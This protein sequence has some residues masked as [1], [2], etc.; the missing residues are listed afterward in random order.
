MTTIQAPTTDSAQNFQL[1]R[2]PRRPGGG[3]SWADARI[4]AGAAPTSLTARRLP[5]QAASGCL[6]ASDLVALTNL[7]V[8]DSSAMDGWAVAGSPPWR[9]VADLPAGQV[10][11]HRL[12][13]GQCVRIATGAVVPEGT[14][15]VLPVERSLLHETG[16]R[17]TDTDTDAAPRT[18][19]RL[20]GEEARRGDVLLPAGTRVT[21]PVLGLAAAAGHDTLPVIP[22]ATVDVF[23][24]G[25]ELSFSGVPSPGRTR[26]ALGPQLPAWLGSFGAAPPSIARLP[27]HLRDLTAALA[28]SAANLIITTG[29]TS[30]G[31]RDHVHAAVEQAGGRVVV[32]GVHVKPGH[33]MLLAALPGDRWLV[34]L[35]GNPFA[36]CAALIT[37]V[38]PLLEGLHGLGPAATVTAT[39]ATAE[40]GRPGDGHRLLP[41]RRDPN[42]LATVLPSCGAA[43][44]RGLAQATG[45]VVI[46]PP[47]AAAG[48]EVEYLPLPWQ[49]LTR[50]I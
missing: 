47:G 18:H 16:V 2:R 29:G 3:M 6:L 21:P 46:T 27:D 42:G 39:L 44:L 15:A 33:P 11:G 28:T 36:A 13:D 1:A 12:A 19:I 43:M 4:T 20:A 9:V 22:P 45:L 30:V 7:P 31:P 41:V 8:A 5:L 50:A 24:L 48:D 26:D 35:P 38:R 14:D 32:D 49:Q 25:D 17:P 10:M 34:G 23:V 40:P 37:L